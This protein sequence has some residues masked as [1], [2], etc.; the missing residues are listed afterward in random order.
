MLESLLQWQHLSKLCKL[1]AI[2]KHQV[3]FNKTSE[4]A[5]LYHLDN[6]ISHIQAAFKS[7][8]P[9]CASCELRVTMLAFPITK[10]DGKHKDSLGN[11]DKLLHNGGV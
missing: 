10:H 6:C 9:L 7:T 3:L 4:T 5:N 1:K 8:H 2:I 11:F